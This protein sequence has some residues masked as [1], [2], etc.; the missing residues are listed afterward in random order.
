ME[1]DGLAFFGDMDNLSGSYFILLISNVWP[2][3][4][5]ILLL[6]SISIYSYLKISRLRRSPDHG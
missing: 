5:G 6:E 2:M 4:W 3:Q 1:R